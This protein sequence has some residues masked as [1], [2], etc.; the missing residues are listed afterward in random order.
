MGE[1]LAVDDRTQIVGRDDGVST[2]R[3][4]TGDSN[5]GVHSSNTQKARNP[6]QPDN[7]V[8]AVVNATED[9]IADIDAD[10]IVA[11]SAVVISAAVT[12]YE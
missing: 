8:V 2:C 11:N 7:D 10:T 5:I 9:S 6:N 1:K 4:A 3:N 12:N